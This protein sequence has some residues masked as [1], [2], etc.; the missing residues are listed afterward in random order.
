MMRMLRRRGILRILGLS[1]AD[2]PRSAKP[3]TSWMRPDVSNI[4]QSISEICQHNLK[5][6]DFAEQLHSYLFPTL[7]GSR[8]LAP[9]TVRGTT[10]QIEKI[11]GQI[12]PDSAD[13]SDSELAKHI[14]AAQRRDKGNGGNTDCR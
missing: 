13:T 14:P 4:V 7:K 3:L 10:I 6:R 9:D 5:V 1:E 8:V 12:A 2:S 11:V